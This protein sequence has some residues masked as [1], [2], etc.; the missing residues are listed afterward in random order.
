MKGIRKIGRT[1]IFSDGSDY[2]FCCALSHV[3]GLPAL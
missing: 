2:D 3:L 1:G